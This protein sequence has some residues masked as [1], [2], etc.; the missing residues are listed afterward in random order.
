MAFNSLIDEKCSKNDQNLKRINLWKILAFLLTFLPKISIKR[1]I[2]K[3]ISTKPWGQLISVKFDQNGDFK[4]KIRLTGVLLSQEVNVIILDAVRGLTYKRIKFPFV[5]NGTG[6]KH[7][8]RKSVPI[9]DYSLRVFHK[10][11]HFDTDICDFPLY[12]KY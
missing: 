10:G 1:L 5:C 8:L 12:S 2:L 11:V 6:C 3:N 4:T 7:V 9:E